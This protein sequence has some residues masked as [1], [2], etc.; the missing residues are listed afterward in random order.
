MARPPRKSSQPVIVKKPTGMADVVFGVL[1]QAARK[2]LFIKPAYKAIFYVGFIAILSVLA[3]NVEM[4]ENY[5]TQKHNFINVYGT[6]LG[7]FWTL[8]F[9]TPFIGLTSYLHHN[10][11][12]LTLFHLLRLVVATAFWYACTNSFVVFEQLTGKCLGD[13][14]INRRTC[15]DNG[16]KW[17]PG[18][19][20]SGHTFILLYSI[21]LISEEA[22]SF[23]NWPTRPKI[24]DNTS[25]EKSRFES[26]EH[27]RRTKTV[28][29]L[30]LCL[31][32]IHLVWDFQL[33]ITSLYYHTVSH[34]IIGALF[35]V[36]SWF[37]TYG[38]W[39]PRYFPNV[40]IRRLS[41]TFYTVK[42]S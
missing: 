12:Q 10:S 16:G 40:P 31:F 18:F 36:T 1:V 34:K 30:F 6:K 11:A 26:D 13:A 7:W 27:Q 23:R 25:N 41:K 39:Y 35:A 17:I 8:L 29:W 14:A 32:A 37:V 24:L 42:T 22:T 2:F 38:L 21:L 3:L 9:L 5:F 4:S 19:D 28:Q 15:F 20:I 33:I